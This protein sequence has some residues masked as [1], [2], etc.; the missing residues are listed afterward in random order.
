MNLGNK[1]NFSPIIPFIIILA[2]IISLSPTA[3]FAQE[4]A[5]NSEI[6]NITETTADNIEINLEENSI[7]ENNSQECSFPSYKISYSNVI[8][9]NNLPKKAL[10]ISDNPGTNIL[11]DAACDVLNTYKD[12]DIQVRSC[13]QVCKMNENELY[14]LVETSDIVI[15]NWLTSDADSVFTN[16]LLKYPNLSNKELFLFLE[17]SSSSQ[18]KNLHLVRNSTIN[19][20][21]I[22]SDKSI[23]TEEFLNNYF[24]MTKRGQNYDVYYE[25]ITNGDGKL[26]NA[27]F[28]KAVLYKNYNNKENQINEI[29]WALNITGYECKYSDPRFSKTYEYGIFREQYM[30]LEEYKKKY[31]DSS[32]PYTVGL[33]ESNMYVSNGQLQPYYALIKSL[34][35]KGCN[36]IPVVAA[37]G[38]ENQLKVMVK[39]F[40]NAPSYEAYLN[41]PLKYTNNVNAIISMPAYGIGGNL[42]DNTTKYFETAGVPVFRAVHSDYVSNEEWELSATGLPGN[43]SD[44]WWH[45]AIG[46]AQGII[47]ATFVGG[48][49]H[50]IS[51]KTGAQLSGFKA[52][53][54]NIDLFTKRIVS[55]INLQYTVNSDKKISLVYFNYPPGKQNIGSSYL[56][57]I[58]SV[59][60][61][62]YELK[63]QG[64]N[65]GKLP[66]TV[67]EL[68][69]MMI[70]SGINVATWAPG[71]LEKL[72]N[73]PNIV[74]LPVAEYENWFNS[75][76]PISK[77][78]VIEGPV[79][80]I[81]QLARNAIAINYTSPM[82]DI[83]SDWYNGV[84]S[85]LP[86]NYT[87]SGVMLLDKIV[88]AL[89][90]YLQSGN[91]SDYQEYLSLKSQWKALNIPGLNGWG[92][93]PGNIMTVTKN[94]V[95]YFVIPGLKFG[96]I[97][98]APEPQRGWEAKSDL[99]YHSSAV[100]PTH[101][102]LAAYYYMQKEYS[103]AMVFIGR[104]ATHEWL[105]GKEVLLST[106]D[107]G[108]IVVGD[109]P[110]IYFYISDGLG[111]GLEAKRRGFAVMI[112]HLTSPLAYTSLYGNLT[113]IANLINKYEN[114]TDKTQK[115]TIASNIKLLIEKNNYIQSMGLTQEEFEKL[116]LN[117]VVKA[118]DKFLF[119][120]TFIEIFLSK[121]FKI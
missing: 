27:E 72:S 69:D 34:E 68:E 49:T 94:G 104:H 62:L 61:L 117:E 87:E 102:Y 88:A 109:V 101:Q 7:C 4:N 50:E 44:K 47:E 1:K 63:S 41:N 112:T 33:L 115:D 52:H 10:L 71:E 29:L 54:K 90:K 3:I 5:T 76:E 24:S 64:Y 43:R 31:F 86:E 6:Q 16:L 96:N 12:V 8:K 42:F 113:A 74:L 92:K 75:L 15:I 59:Y 2:I 11:N 13:N 19:H 95:A 103:S 39:Y 105:P 26:V 30:T 48:V 51:S 120:L 100:A 46:E 28:N 116:N 106:T 83:I 57:S 93:A 81:G 107:Y 79:A 119:I 108:S 18:A 60:N 36:V 17:T 84:K 22:F 97:F 58:T 89:N 82:K 37:G 111:E 110:Q 67:K 73:Q 85:L 65:V 118:A 35:A 55:W 80:Y 56:D 70:K 45:V 66:T 32:R 91:D 77:V 9:E 20:E 21:K 78:Q 53:E 98:I 25:Y 114:T 14:N 40:T 38:S 99:L 121:S 23:Y